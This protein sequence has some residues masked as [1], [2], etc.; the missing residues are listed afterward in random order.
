MSFSSDLKNEL[1]DMQL[2][3]NCC[4]KAFLFGLII[5]AKKIGNKNLC[6]EFPIECVALKTVQLLKSIYLIDKGLFR[7]SISFVSPSVICLS[8]SLHT[9]Y[10]PFSDLLRLID[11]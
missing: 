5:N 6:I 2:K 1:L 7:F 9:S 8:N 10:P 3:K 11:K 4:K